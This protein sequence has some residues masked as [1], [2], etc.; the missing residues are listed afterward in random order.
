MLHRT[1]AVA[2]H[3]ILS[4]HTH[5]R[6]SPHTAHSPEPLDH[7]IDMTRT[8]S[9][10]FYHPLAPPSSACA[11]RV[12][13]QSRSRNRLPTTLGVTLSLVCMRQGER[14]Q[15]EEHDEPIHLA[16]SGMRVRTRSC[17][18]RSTAGTPCGS[19]DCDEDCCLP[20]GV[21]G[22]PTVLETRVLPSLVKC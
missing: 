2:A 10:Q 15:L 17:F 12:Q 9:S 1:A 8:Y 7:A 13:R 20:E 5:A 22:V 14:P 18:P 11:R 16:Y 6:R 19:H 4:V 21:L 3:R